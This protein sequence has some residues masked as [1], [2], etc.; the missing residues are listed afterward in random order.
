M[1]LAKDM[2]VSIYKKAAGPIV[3]DGDVLLSDENNATIEHAGKF[4]LCGCGKTRSSPFCD[5]SHK[6]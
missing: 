3:V 6:R 1:E 5:G 4:S 2:K